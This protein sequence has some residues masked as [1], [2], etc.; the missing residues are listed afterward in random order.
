MDDSL[1]PPRMMQELHNRCDSIRKQLL[2]IPAGTH[3]ETWQLQGYYRSMA[4][5]LQ[6]CRLDNSVHVSFDIKNEKTTSNS[7]WSDVQTI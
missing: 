1:V 7:I 6:S 2:Q 3:N 4:V 5:F